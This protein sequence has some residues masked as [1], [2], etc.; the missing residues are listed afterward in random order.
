MS[1]EAEQTFIYQ[2]C[3]EPLPINLAAIFEPMYTTAFFPLQAQPNNHMLQF[4]CN[5]LVKQPMERPC[6]S[7]SPVNAFWAVQY[8]S[9]LHR[10]F[11]QSP[12]L[13]ALKMASDLL[14]I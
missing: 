12:V 4:V 1:C 3:K 10:V 11:P 2:P 14:E 13:S 5:S 8:Q 7:F 6:T 9:A